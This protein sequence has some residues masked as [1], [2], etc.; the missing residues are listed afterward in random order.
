MNINQCSKIKQLLYA[1]DFN[2]VVQGVVL[3]ETLLA[4][5]L[6]SFVD[7]LKEIAGVHDYTEDIYA[8]DRIF[9][10]EK[11]ERVFPMCAHKEYL[12]LWTLGTLALFPEMKTDTEN[13][14][15]LMR[16]QYSA[17]QL[18]SNIG[19]LT[20]LTSIV[21]YNGL[22]ESLPE[23]L[24]QLHRLEKLLLAGNHLHLL[25][26]TFCSLTQLQ[27]FDIR[28]NKVQYLPSNAE[29]LSKLSVLLLDD[30]PGLPE[31]FG[32]LS[33][34][35]IPTKVLNKMSMNGSQFCLGM[36]VS[37]STEI[38]TLTVADLT[39]QLFETSI[40]SSTAYTTPCTGGIK[41]FFPETKKWE[42]LLIQYWSERDMNMN[43]TEVDGAVLKKLVTSLHCGD[44]TP[45]Q[46]LQFLADRADQ[47]TY[48]LSGLY[49]SWVDNYDLPVTWNDIGA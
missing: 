17:T 18:P 16:H 20:G 46:I 36:D 23:S 5:D 26:E 47:Y 37:G 8:V 14:T 41:V 33:L 48:G 22:L 15:T 35:D 44:V 45:L 24:G 13:L 19:N 28:R 29:N 12:V 49:D 39:L 43:L 34:N 7:S 21:M 31:E 9:S 10:I 40:S 42:S 27:I 30:T 1:N 32:T 25:P 11:L 38:C 2:S 4:S 6:I 3:W